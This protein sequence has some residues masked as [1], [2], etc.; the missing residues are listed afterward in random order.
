MLTS[1]PQA[2]PADVCAKIRKEFQSH[3]AHN[4][5]LTGELLRVLELF[6]TNQVRSLPFKG[7]ALARAAHGNTLLRDFEDLDV[8]VHP[9]QFQTARQILVNFGYRPDPRKICNQ[10]AAYVRTIRQLPMVRQENGVT[11]ELHSHFTVRDFAFPINLAGVFERRLHIEIDGRKVPT[12]GYEDHLLV[13]AVHGGK[14]LWASLGWIAD[15]HQLILAHPAMN[16]P[17]LI[18]EAHRLRCGRL[19]MLALWLTFHLLDTPLPEELV[20]RLGQDP[21]VTQLG[22]QTALRLFRHQ[23]R[24][25]TTIE[26][27]RF[28]LKARESLRDGVSYALSLAFVPSSSDWS[29]F[30]LPRAVLFSLL[31]GSSRSACHQGYPQHSPQKNDKS[32]LR[33]ELSLG[34][35]A[36]LSVPCIQQALQSRFECGQ[37]EF[38]VRTENNPVIQGRVFT[39]LANLDAVAKQSGDIAEAAFRQ[40]ENIRFNQLLHG[41]DWVTVQNKLRARDI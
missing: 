40:D 13:A 24:S 29:L 34:P 3:A 11:F 27:A 25:P 7:P 35:S 31:P 19:L 17:W 16:W 1:L 6:D 37:I 33:D 14:H 15:V 20:A 23:D 2:P 8:L 5:Q 38:T 18:E 4:I 28:F 22:E 26:S 30:S 21:V 39:L 41:P 36:L 12:L 32:S 9:G 10:E